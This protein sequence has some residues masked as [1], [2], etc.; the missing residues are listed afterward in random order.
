MKISE[1]TASKVGRKYQHIEDLVLSHGSHGGLHAIERLRDMAE[2]GGTI[3]LKWDG[4]P[5]VYW[6][7]DANGQFMM[8]PKNAWAYL[9]SGK[10]QT[11][12]GA[13]TIMK[14]PKDVKNFILGTGQGTSKDRTD[15]ANQFAGLWKY[16]EKISPKKGFLEGGLLFYPGTKPNGANAMPLH[17]KKTGTYDFQP[18]ITTFHVPVDSDLGKKIANAKMMVAVTGYFDS[19]GSSD[20]SRFNDATSLSTPDVIVQGTVYVQEPAKIN[21]SGLTKL[22][23]YIQ[24]NKEVI[25]RFLSPKPGLSNP[26]GEIYTYLNKRL[27]TEGLTKDFP[28]WAQANLSAKKAETMLSDK[29]GMIATLGS[30][31]ALNKA[32][33][34][35]VDY[36]SQGSHGGIK[37]TRPEGYAQ[38]H[39]GKNFKYDIPGQFIKTIDQKTWKPEPSYVKESKTQPRAVLGWGRG[40]GHT[41]HD[42]LVTAVIHQAKKEQAQP[43]FIVSRSFGKDDPLPPETKVKLY[44]KKFPEYKN[45]FSLPDEGSASI[46]DVLTKLAKK[47]YKHVTLVVG[48]DQKNQFGYL[49]NPNKR[50]ELPYKTFGL[51]GISI[52][53]RQDTKAP[54]SDESSS[55]YHEGPRATPMREVLLDPS[56]TEKQQFKVWRASM[57]SA[58]S[59]AEVLKLMKIAKKNLLKFH[60]PK[61]KKAKLK[62]NT[63]QDLDRKSI[64]ATSDE[65]EVLAFIKKHYPEA[66]TT[67]AAFIK[68]VINSLTHSD[69]DSNRHDREIE[70]L[71]RELDRLE[72]KMNAIENSPTNEATLVRDPE[73]GDLII[74]DGGMG[75]W[76]EHTLKSNLVRKLGSIAQMIKDGEYQRVYQ[77]IYEVGTIKRILE[78][79]AQYQ[80]YTAN[81]S[82]VQ[83][84]GEI[85][86]TDYLD[87]K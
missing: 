80:G 10:T 23:K 38:A 27:R 8:I 36:L 42:A 4:M 70:T 20:E 17:N 86:I 73:Q 35:L 55:D 84:T 21:L 47:G 45:I 29:E 62:E 46:N 76:D 13:S 78:A 26:A 60:A 67:Q 43:F 6:G 22:E 85:D 5:V 24:T 12:S 32:K 57:N 30:I 25:D 7:R 18:N 56:K 81:A 2:S 31:E 75:T 14:S 74:P 15:F 68:F 11:S 48:A 66:P 44:K 53:S 83:T 52:L 51:D 28:A 33:T 63:E 1:A 34:Q 19:L 58:I 37:Q 49:I 59:D 69:E 39:P 16:F 79:L 64:N 87:E 72:Q 41:G 65:N 71:N 61:P 82:D 3:E 40:M 50:G 54:G 77:S 9:K